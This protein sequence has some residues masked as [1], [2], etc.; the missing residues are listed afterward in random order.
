MPVPGPDLH[1]HSTASDGTVT[2]SGLVELAATVCCPAIAL[3]DHD[4]TDGVAEA[5]AASRGTSV[6]VVPGVELSAGIGERGMHIL[7]YHVDH[8]DPALRARLERLREVRVERAERIVYALSEAGFALTIAEVLDAADGGSVGRAHI[9]QRLVVT[10]QVPSVREAFVRLLG[11]AAPYYVP[12]PVESPGDVIGWIRKAGGVP[13]LAH[14]GLSRVDDLIPSLVEVGLLGIEAYHPAHDAAATQ[15]YAALAADLGMIATG[16]S[17]FHGLD[18]E[19]DSL[20]SVGVPAN[21]TA[22][23]TAAHEAVTR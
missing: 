7:G 22:A 8:N 15:H 10:G 2:P 4:T 14:P 21:V 17:D 18:R 11:S 12:K 19:G 13:V 3:T 23:L 9:A 5:L 1:L 6:T 20:G 16:G